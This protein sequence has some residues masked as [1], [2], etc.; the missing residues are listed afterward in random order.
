[1]KDA[2]DALYSRQTEADKKTFDP[3]LEETNKTGFVPSRGALGNRF[4]T[5]LDANPEER[6]KYE[7]LKGHSVKSDFRK[8]W[9]DDEWIKYSKKRTVIENLAECWSDFGKYEPFEVIAGKESGTGI[10]TTGATAALNICM[11]CIRLGGYWCRYNWQSKRMEY[12]YMKSSYQY[13]FE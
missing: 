10:T 5:Y 1:M 4:Q 3:Y 8:K 12:L 6:V 7:K 2:Q 13:K 11:S 9:F